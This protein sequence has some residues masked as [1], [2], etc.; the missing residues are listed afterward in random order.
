MKD[1]IKAI[2]L[3]SGGLD[4]AVMLAEAIEKGRECHA[5]CFDYGQRHRLEI[6]SAQNICRHYNVPL[7]IVKI[8]PSAFRNSSLIS[9]Q[10]IPKNRSPSEIAVSGIPSTYVPARNTIFLAFA[11]GHAE[12]INAQ[13]IYYG[14]N[15]DD[16]LPYPDCREEFVTA[17]Q[18]VM[19]FATAQ[20]TTTQ[21]PKLITPLVKLTKIEIIKHGLQLKTPFELTLS[22]YDPTPLAHHCGTCDAC[23]LRKNGFTLAKIDDPTLYKNP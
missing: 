16:A 5:I 6:R 13:E 22:C 14:P 18:Q 12:L 20:A 17:F 10:S 8:D 23:I 3:I 2:L 11:A 15:L 4:S 1:Q 19:N 7:R 21:P 9:S